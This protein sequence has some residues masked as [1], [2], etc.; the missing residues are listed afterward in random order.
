[1]AFFGVPCVSDSY[2][3]LCV[4]DPAKDT[5]ALYHYA[6]GTSFIPSIA[7][8]V[9][10]KN[11]QRFTIFKYSC[12]GDI[13]FNCRNRGTNNGCQELASILPKPQ[14]SEQTSIAAIMMR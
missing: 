11:L 10:M 2:L 3:I 13:L 9:V 7:F 8:F 5:R 4:Q 12:I 14:L 1:M 6:D